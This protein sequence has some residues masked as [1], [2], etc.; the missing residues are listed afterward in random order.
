MKT[1]WE[2]HTDFADSMQFYRRLLAEAPA[3]LKPNSHLIMEIEYQQAET[4]KA[5]VDCN[6]WREPKT[7]RD[8]QGIERTLVLALF[9]A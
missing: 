4:I 1:D 2:P 9:S 8:L 3:H 7:L 6:V 5:F